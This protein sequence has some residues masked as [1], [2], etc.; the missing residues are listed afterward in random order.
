M[1]V[2]SEEIPE[3]QEINEN[4]RQPWDRLTGRE[5]A[6]DE[7]PKAYKAFLDYCTM[8]R[9]RTIRKLHQEY[10][11]QAEE[12]SQHEQ[13]GREPKY[14]DPPTTKANTLYTWS[15]RYNWKDRAEAYQERQDWEK[16]M[17]QQEEI[18]KMQD[19]HA[20]IARM[21]Q[22]K[23]LAR[24]QAVDAAELSIPQVRQWVQTAVNIERLSRGVNTESVDHQIG[25]KPDRP[26]AG[27][28]GDQKSSLEDP[29][30]VREVMQEL[31]E[32]APSTFDTN[33][34]ASG[35]E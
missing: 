12:N 29:G 23:L 11:Q 30:F 22:Q 24:L 33:G 7:T 10:V 21:M 17:E 15:A 20:N 9:D 8:G 1:P 6:R 31:Q 26:V 32:H 34:E 25:E 4:H 16:A 28:E 35:S 2:T 18:D 19:R 13:Q 27:P 14:E 5:D 3:F